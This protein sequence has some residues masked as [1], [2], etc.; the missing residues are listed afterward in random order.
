MSSSLIAGN[1]AGIFEKSHVPP[2]SAY[3]F[4]TSI[5]FFTH[6]YQP[7]LKRR[8]YR[9]LQMEHFRLSWETNSISDFSASFVSF[10]GSEGPRAGKIGFFRFPHLLAW[11]SARSP[12]TSPFWVNIQCPSSLFF[13]SVQ[14]VHKGDTSFYYKINTLSFFMDHWM[15][16]W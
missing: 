11:A 5:K 6:G 12:E 4:R 13:S 7:P 2:R 9:C 1:S 8:G 16:E 3:F 15:I 10:Q 14:K